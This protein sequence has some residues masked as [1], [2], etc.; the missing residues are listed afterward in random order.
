MTTAL[1]SQ[2]VVFRLLTSLC[3]RYGLGTPSVW[4]RGIV[5]NLPRLNDFGFD[6]PLNSSCSLCLYLS[7]VEPSCAHLL[8]RT[9]PA[10]TTRWFPSE[11]ATGVSGRCL[12]DVGFGSLIAEASAKPPVS[13]CGPVALSVRC[14][15]YCCPRMTFE[16]GHEFLTLAQYSCARKGYVCIAWM[17]SSCRETISR[18]ERKERSR[19]WI[20][21]EELSVSRRC[22]RQAT[23]ASARTLVWSMWSR[24]S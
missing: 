4:L 6:Y 14:P 16:P 11:R 17:R 13:L 1:G 21:V 12:N 7:G 9:V 24:Y 22:L 2:R 23:L 19:S 18:Q 8:S 3:L 15:D 20:K 10:G 5:C